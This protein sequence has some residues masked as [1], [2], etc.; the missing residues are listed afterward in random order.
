MSSQKYAPG[1]YFY[2]KVLEEGNS[3]AAGADEGSRLIRESAGKNGPAIY[4][5]AEARLEGNRLDKD[6][7]KGMD[8]MR[9]A[10][11]HGSRSAQQFLGQAYEKGAPTGADAEKSRHYFRI[12]AKGGDSLC[13]F[14][15]GKSLLEESGRSERDYVQ[16]IA[17]LHVAANQGMS[18]A[19]ELLS[20][21]DAHL[22]PSQIA[23]ARKLMMQRA[24]P[25]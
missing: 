14:R 6:P 7:E 2:G 21:E 11:R 5:I 15:L 4:E 19:K 18:G 12:C 25:K 3:V 23:D 13:Q 20:H 24:P 8:L 16:A 1:M 17:W 10:A 22:T 9:D